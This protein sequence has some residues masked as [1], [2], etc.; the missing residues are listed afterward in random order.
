MAPTAFRARWK[1]E[2]GVAIQRRMA[3]M[4]RAVLPKE[5]GRQAW[6][7]G[8]G[9]REGGRLPALEEDEEEEKEK[10]AEALQDED[11]EEKEVGDEQQQRVS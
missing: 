1:H 7:A 8:A 4:L 3:A 5:R 6:L 9:E 11:K 10:D 2:I